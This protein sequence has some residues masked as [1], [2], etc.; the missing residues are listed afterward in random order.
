MWSM[1][2]SARFVSEQ[3][4]ASRLPAALPTGMLLLADRSCSG[5]PP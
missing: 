1:L 5:F 4:L 2:R 3:K